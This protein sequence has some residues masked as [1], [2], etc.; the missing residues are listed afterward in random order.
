M[1][2][3]SLPSPPPPSKRGGIAEE[4]P[5]YR[6]VSTETPENAS[7]PMEAA[8]AAAAEEE[9]EE[10]EE[11]SLRILI[12]AEA[13][14][15]R[16]GGR[17]SERNGAAGCPWGVSPP[18]SHFVPPPTARRR[19]ALNPGCPHLICQWGS[20]ECSRIPIREQVLTGLESNGQIEKVEWKS[21]PEEPGT[22]EGE[23]FEDCGAN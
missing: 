19:A 1:N 9:E 16:W 21:F 13:G 20:R 3:N 8:A 2:V 14:G 17:G 11:I 12:R 18:I 15:L 23:Q 4:P 6:T 7:E 10:E 5:Q 22:C